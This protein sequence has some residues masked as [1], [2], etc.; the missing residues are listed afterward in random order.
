MIPFF[1]KNVLP[2]IGSIP[3][4]M[5]SPTSSDQQ[6]FSYQ[7]CLNIP[8][9]DTLCVIRLSPET[10]VPE[11][12]YM[13]PTPF[14]PMRC[15]SAAAI[16]WNLQMRCFNGK[17]PQRLLVTAY[18]ISASLMGSG[19]IHRLGIMSYMQLQTYQTAFAKEDFM[20]TS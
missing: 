2:A 10:I 3:Q 7:M 18:P 4:P 14:N 1:V 16:M 5:V 6:R 8:P 12:Q 17:W 11:L 19:S 15:S 20:L 13:R 9:Y